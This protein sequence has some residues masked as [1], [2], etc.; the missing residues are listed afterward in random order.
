MPSDH[1]PVIEKISLHVII[2]H[3]KPQTRC[4][5]IRNEQFTHQKSKINN[6]CGLARDD[7]FTHEKLK[8]NIP[9][10]LFEMNSLHVKIKVQH[11]M[12]FRS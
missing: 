8:P 11:L 5:L 4:S 6:Q 12:R 9:C 1:S 2:L 10:G 7:Q 3:I